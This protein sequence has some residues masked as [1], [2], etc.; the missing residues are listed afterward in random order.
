[1][2]R[3]ITILLLLI[4]AGSCLYAADSLQVSSPD[5]HISVTLYCKGSI[6]YTVQY[7]GKTILQPSAINLLP[8]NQPALSANPSVRTSRITRV[9]DTIVSPVPEKRVIIPDQY[10]Q[11]TVQ[12]RQPYSLIFR[13]YN[14]G[15]AYRITTRFKDSLVVSNEQAQFVFERGK[16]LLFPLIDPAGRTDSFHTSFEELYRPVSID[17]ITGSSFAYTPVLAGSG[18]E[19]KVAITESDLEDYPGMFL[20]G[21]AGNALEGLFAGYPLETTMTNGEFPQEVVTRRASY[22]ART[23]GA[24]NFPWRVLIIAPEDKDLPGND[25]VYRLA[26][27]SK[28]RDVSWIR[29]GKGTDEWIIGINLFNVPFKAG[30]NTATYKFYIDFAQQFGFD[31]IMLDAGWSD[32][33]D[34]FR[35]NPALSMDTLAAYARQKGIRLSMWTLCSTLDRQLDSALKQFQRWGVDFIMTDFMDRDD[36]PMVNFYERISKA[37]AEHQIMIMFHGAYP[38]KG[39]TRTWPNNITREGVLGSEYNIWSDKPTPE[40]NVTLPF[41]RMLAGPMDY[42]PGIL[43]NATKEQFRPISKKV[44]SQGTRCHQLAMFVV[45]DSPL[46][47]FAGNPSQ[48]MLEP[49]FMRLLGSLPTTWDETKIVAGRVGDYIVTA[50][51]KGDDWYIAG[52]TDGE[53]RDITFPVDF[54][55]G[56]YEETICGDGLNAADYPSD[57]KLSTREAA[58]TRGNITRV[59]VKTA[60]GGGFLIRFKKIQSV[61]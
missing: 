42:E 17:S 61:P 54:L 18:D 13:V 37:C 9:N 36:Q 33:K 44:M 5:N 59:V 50:R 8:E 34:L 38:P 48:G 2:I 45:Y 4:A 53:A 35:I 1:M 21:T 10:N 30:I 41:T 52:M 32:Y 43:D 28:I 47:I 51:R 6:R 25:L 22:I 16:R 15:V 12:F 29:P 23:K 20:R 11:L 46:Q 56:R 24:R 19:I 31:R 14:D 26:S 3:H 60:P 27:A 39:F 7:K 49:A 57:Y 58:F 40:H 55:D